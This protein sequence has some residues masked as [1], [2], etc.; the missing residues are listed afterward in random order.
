MNC[1]QELIH[2][3]IFAGFTAHLANGYYLCYVLVSS[4]PDHPLPGRPP[5]IRTFSLPGG[6]ARS[7]C[8]VVVQLSLPGGQGFEFEKFSEVS[9][10]KC[11]NSSVC[12]KK[13]E[14]A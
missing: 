8:R 5:E 7:P 10:E 3:T 14:A 12:F 1:K 4:K 13:P 11:R 2:I 9:K 6:T